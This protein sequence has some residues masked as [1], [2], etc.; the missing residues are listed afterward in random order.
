MQSKRRSN[1]DPERLSKL[2]FIKYNKSLH[3]RFQT[4]R[5]QNKS[6]DYDPIVID[7]LNYSSEWMTGR[8]GACN[9]FVY[10][11]D[12]FTWAEV[13]FCYTFYSSSY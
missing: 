13:T 3:E 5:V 9:E 6:E 8:P 11:E 12:G 1:L 10:E 7:D 4:R 2:V